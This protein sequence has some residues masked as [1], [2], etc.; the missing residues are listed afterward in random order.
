MS[1]LVASRGDCGFWGVTIKKKGGVST[2]VFNR[3]TFLML[4]EEKEKRVRK[5]NWARHK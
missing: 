2:I 1:C 3:Y 5:E 4:Q